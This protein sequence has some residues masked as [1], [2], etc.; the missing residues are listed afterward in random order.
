MVGSDDG[1]L[2]SLG[3][4]GLIFDLI[5]WYGGLSVGLVS[6]SYL[7]VCLRKTVWSDG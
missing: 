1:L 4:G 5:V 6:W 3:C 2:L 7:E